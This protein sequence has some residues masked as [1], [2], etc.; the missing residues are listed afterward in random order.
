MPVVEWGGL[1]GQD[2]AGGYQ[3]G[4]G[5]SVV[6]LLAHLKPEAGR[7]VGPLLQALVIVEQVGECGDGDEDD[8]QTGND[9]PD[10]NTISVVQSLHRTVRLSRLR[11]WPGIHLTS[12]GTDNLH[13]FYDT[14]TPYKWI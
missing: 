3:F 2:Q 13:T 8:Q 10:P 5:G 12:G 7:A 6:G 9:R 4:G 14:I 1:V 11:A